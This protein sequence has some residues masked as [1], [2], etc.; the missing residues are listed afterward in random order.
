MPVIGILT[1]RV[2]NRLLVCCGF[3][4]TALCCLAFARSDLEIS[5]WSL[6]WPIVFS[7]ASVSLIFVPL[8]AATMG[9]LPNEEIGNASGLYNLMRNV[10]GSIGIS[11]V[12]TVLARHEQVHRNY[13]VYAITNTSH[14][15]RQQYQ[16][17]WAFVTQQSG[18]TTAGRQVYKLFERSLDQQAA[19]LSY[20]DNFRYIA[21]LCFFC[22]PIAF[23]MKRVRGRGKTSMAH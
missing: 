14:T 2:D 1:D 17:V 9:T 20:V 5:Q 16:A 23:A 8:A 13:L 15:F 12:N 6:L 22:A 4:F 7:G 10:G 19:L 18:L 21:F 3:T 11:I